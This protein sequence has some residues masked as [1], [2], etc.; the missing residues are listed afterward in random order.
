MALAHTIGDKVEADYRRG[1][2]IAKSREL[3]QDWA[4][5]CG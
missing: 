1:E 3:M 5:Y 4:T 2:L